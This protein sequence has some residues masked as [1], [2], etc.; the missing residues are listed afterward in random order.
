MTTEI[1]MGE[2]R[3]N[4]KASEVTVINLTFTLNEMK[5]VGGL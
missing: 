4:G 2:R 3:I 1:E 5:S